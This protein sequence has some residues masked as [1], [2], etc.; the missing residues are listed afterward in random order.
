MP[1]V[2]HRKCLGYSFRLSINSSCRKKKILLEKSDL[3]QVDVYHLNFWAAKQ[4]HTSEAKVYTLFRIYVVGSHS[5]FPFQVVRLEKGNRRVQLELKNTNQQQETQ[6][7]Q[8]GWR[9]Q[10]VAVKMSCNIILHLCYIAFL[11]YLFVLFVGLL[12]RAG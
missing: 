4:L 2:E 6:N 10:T 3:L 5:Y 12:G 9:T 11:L 1:G 7:R 8:V